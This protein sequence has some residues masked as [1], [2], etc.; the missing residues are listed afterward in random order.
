M[1]SKE[2]HPAL[3]SN[4]NEYKVLRR[5][6]L[7]AGILTLV[8]R[9]QEAHCPVIRLIARELVTRLVLQPVMDFASQCM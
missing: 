6:R 3:V 7:V 5:L 1:A 2:L 8:L 9:P 4:E